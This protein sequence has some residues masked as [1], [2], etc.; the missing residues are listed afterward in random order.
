MRRLIQFRLTGPALD[1]ALQFSADMRMPLNQLA[2]K[3][4][5]YAMQ[6]AYQKSKEV[7][8][9]DQSHVG[10][11]TPVDQSVAGEVSP[12]SGPTSPP[13][14]DEEISDSSDQSDS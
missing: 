5:I 2:E 9:N 7:V 14:A 1:A 10:R 4:L 13:L 11:D 12:S 6:M 8:P 3:S